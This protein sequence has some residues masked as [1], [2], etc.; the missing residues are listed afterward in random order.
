MPPMERDK[1][2]Q[3][4]NE[5]MGEVTETRKAEILQELRADYSG[6][7]RDHETHTETIHKLSRDKEDL[8][9]ANSRLFRENGVYLDDKKKDEQV[10][11]QTFSETV[12]L[13]QLEKQVN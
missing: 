11:E 3:L 13:E 5:I 1:H 12:T 2:E 6:V 7:L 4:L 8:I 9:V 10:A